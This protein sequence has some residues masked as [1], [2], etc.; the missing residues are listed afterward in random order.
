MLNTGDI[1]RRSTDN[2]QSVKEK[3]NV[4]IYSHSSSG[5]QGKYMKYFMFGFPC[6]VI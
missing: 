1:F 5:G 2:K 3:L 6:I 4:E